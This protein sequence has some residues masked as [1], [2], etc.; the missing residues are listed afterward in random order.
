M[1]RLRTILIGAALSFTILGSAAGAA[2]AQDTTGPHPFGS[3][4]VSDVAQMHTGVGTH[5]RSMHSNVGQ[6]LQDMR[7]VADECMHHM[8]STDS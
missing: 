8:E 6:H 4:C 7:T 3:E 1:K 5:I 2:A